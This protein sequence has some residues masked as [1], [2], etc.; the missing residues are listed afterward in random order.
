MSALSQ[1]H[2][3]NSHTVELSVQEQCLRNADLL[4]EILEYLSP[5]CKDFAPSAV[6][7]LWRRLDNI[8]PL[9]RLLPAFAMGDGMYHLIRAMQPH[10]WECF[11]RHAAL[12]KEIISAPDTCPSIASAAYVGLALHNSR[13]LPNM[14]RFTWERTTL[15]VSPPDL[16]ELLLYMQSP[17]QRIDINDPFHPEMGQVIIPF[18]PATPPHISWLTLEGQTPS[19]LFNV[20]PLKHLTDLDL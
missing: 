10:E 15:G 20:A 4:Q 3:S 8:L 7:V 14:E 19:A 18:L 11:E 13:I 2:S 9:L 16:R 17:L 6:K 12:V 1:S 5:T